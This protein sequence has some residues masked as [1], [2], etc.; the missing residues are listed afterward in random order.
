MSGRR[1]A[2][3]MMSR[4]TSTRLFRR[5][6]AQIIWI[7]CCNREEA[8]LDA[9]YNVLGILMARKKKIIEASNP[10]SFHRIPFI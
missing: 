1:F 5:L 10:Q 6:N 2:S 9:T 4:K 8:R 3:F 7:A